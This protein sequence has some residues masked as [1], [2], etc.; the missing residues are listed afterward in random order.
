ME[1]RHIAFLII[2]EA[3]LL[4][5]TGPYEVFSQAKELSQQNVNYKLHT[6]SIGYNKNVRTSSGLTILCESSMQSKDYVID[7]L[8]IP[9]VPN[10]ILDKYKLS[11]KVFKWIKEQ[12]VIVRRICSVCTGTFFLAEA[13]IL[14]GRKATTHWEC[15]DLLSGNYSE[16]KVDSGSIFIKDG[17]VYTSAGI[18]AGMDMALALV[19]EDFG[20]GLALNVARQM[21]LYLKRPGSQSQYSSVLKH[22]HTDHRPILEIESWII[23]HIQEV[24]TVEILAEQVSMSTRNFSRVF[25]RETGASPAKYITK[26]RIETACRYLVDTQLSLKEI[27]GLC[28]LESIDNMR[29]V[30]MKHLKISPRDYRK[31]FGTAF[32]KKQ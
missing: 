25:T 9:G 7:T 29:K 23:E 32:T 13:G 17:N 20:R 10:S 1:F 11:K 6:L 28:G 21:V 31:N 19:E 12:S 24:I 14:N 3:T 2:P 5:I 30:F 18:S 22:Q 27:A 8:F 16:I 26:L 15:C 4:D